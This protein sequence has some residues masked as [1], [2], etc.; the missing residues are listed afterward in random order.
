MSELQVKLD[1]EKRIS[2]EKGAELDSLKHELEEALRRVADVEAELS[3]ARQ[4]QE[5]SECENLKLRFEVEQFKQ[6]SSDF[7]RRMEEMQSSSDSTIETYRRENDE[8]KAKLS[9][10][11]AYFETC[12][13][14]FTVVREQCSHKEAE[15]ASL[16]VQ[17]G[18]ET[19]TVASLLSQIDLL[20]ETV[21]NMCRESDALRMLL[22]QAQGDRTLV[23]AEVRD[24]RNQVSRQ[25]GLLGELE[26]KIGNFNKV[27]Q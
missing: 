23:D 14:K 6:Q 13:S 8:F 3:S 2:K 10:L 9:E 24:L 16:R 15:N 5:N 25:T 1:D 22:E 17:L 12:E 19:A 18:Q 4:D 26:H 7:E 21:E 27:R 20:N 11:V